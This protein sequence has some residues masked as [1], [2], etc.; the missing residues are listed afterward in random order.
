MIPQA[1]YTPSILSM[2]TLARDSGITSPDG[3]AEAAELPKPNATPVKTR[4]WVETNDTQR[5]MSSRH[6]TM[7]GLSWNIWFG[8]LSSKIVLVIALGGTIGTG[9]FLS[10]GIVRWLSLPAYCCMKL[11]SI[12]SRPWRRVV[13]EV[14]CCRILFSA[15]SFSLWWWLCKLII[16]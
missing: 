3:S 6:L 12:A 9:I 16:L 7:I 10:A 5:G 14:H 13:L 4:F 1:S 11:T 8:W 15:Y 2:P